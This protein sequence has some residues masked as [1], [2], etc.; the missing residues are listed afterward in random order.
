MSN[1][2]LCQIVAVEKGIKVRTQADLTKTH[3]DLQTPQLF[4]GLSREYASREDGGEQLPGEGVL[5]QRGAEE[6]LAKAAKLMTELFDVVFTKDMGNTKAFGNVTVDGEVLFTA[7]VPYLLFL[8][9]QLI[10]LR[11]LFSKLPTLDPAELW[12][13]D[14]STAHFR[15]APVKT[16]RTKKVPRVLEL[17][18]ATDKHPAQ[19]Q[20]W[21][22]D[23]PAG[24]WTTVRFSGAVRQTRKDELV[25]R[26]NKLI[27][28]VK[29]AVEEANQTE[30]A[31][32]HIGAKLFGWLLAE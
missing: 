5:V 6:E 22:E 31:Q 19:V 18:K 2:K 27:D 4:L 9:K 11:T 26:A 8:E 20:M 1:P 30:V 7:P 10:D 16:I 13:V 24:T 12:Q 14:P 23:I 32:K 15:T 3:R 21:H 25:A 29:V 28:A 17:A